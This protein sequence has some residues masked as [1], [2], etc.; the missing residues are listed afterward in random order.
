MIPGKIFTS[1]A[2]FQRIVSVNDFRLPIRL[3]ELLLALLCFL[4]SFCF[5][6]IRLDPLGGQ[7]LHHGC[8]SIIVSRFTIFTENFVICCYQ[9]TNFFF[10]TRYGSA[11]ASSTRG[12][13]N[14]GPLTD[15]AISVFM[16]MS[17]NTVLTQIFTSLGCGLQRYFMRRTGV[18]ISVF[19]NSIIHQTFSELLRPLR[20]IGIQQRSTW[21][22]KQQASPFYR[23]FLFMCFFGIFGLAW[24]PCSWLDSRQSTGFSC[25]IINM[26]T[27]HRHWRRINFILILSFSNLT[28]TWYCR[29]WWRR[30]SWGRCRMMPLLSWR[31][32]WSCMMRTGRRTRWQAWNHNRNEVLRVQL[33]PNPVF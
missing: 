5:A 12:P 18:W 31:C 24:R 9:V 3:Q 25:P 6:R 2:K 20:Y 15:L 32:P 28:I 26:W 1:L 27:W 13:C 19:R 29:S 10:C 4:R 16:D 17:I 22:I 11:I 23:G 14:F 21:V 7:I 33:Y 30:R 8:I